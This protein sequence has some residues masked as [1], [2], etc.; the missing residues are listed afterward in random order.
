MSGARARAGGA[1]ASGAARTKSRFP[2][3]TPATTHVLGLLV[4]DGGR[5]LLDLWFLGCLLIGDKRDA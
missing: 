4:R 3:A 2:R 1:R 5:D